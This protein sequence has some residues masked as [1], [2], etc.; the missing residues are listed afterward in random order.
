MDI[1]SKN[2]ASQREEEAK[3]GKE[4]AHGAIYDTKGV[5]RCECGLKW[6]FNSDYETTN[7]DHRNRKFEEA[8]RHFDMYAKRDAQGRHPLDLNK[9]QK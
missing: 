6:D 8:Q 5:I 1:L 3:N 7:A 9:G 4:V 2:K